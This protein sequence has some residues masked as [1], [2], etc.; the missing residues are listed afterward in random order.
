MC[1]GVLQ[2]LINH[3]GMFKAIEG[4]MHSRLVISTRDHMI[5][6]R[7]TLYMQ[8]MP[9]DTLFNIWTCEMMFLPNRSGTNV[10]D[11]FKNQLNNPE[12]CELWV[13]SIESFSH[14]GVRSWHSQ[15]LCCFTGYSTALV[16]D[17]TLLPSILN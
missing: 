15:P 4:A 5:S 10:V 13:T 16:A 2:S 9:Q 3:V 7:C 11:T 14:Q 8:S 1:Q 12:R 6:Y 17:D